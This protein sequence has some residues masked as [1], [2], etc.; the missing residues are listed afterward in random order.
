MKTP[1]NTPT[2]WLVRHGE[3]VDNVDPTWCKNAPRGA[4]DDPTLTNRGHQ[5]AIECGKRLQ[6]EPIDHIFCSPF[7]RCVQTAAGIVKQLKSP[8]TIKVEPGI[9]E[10]LYV[11]Q[12]PPG[13]LTTPELHQLYPDLIDLA[14]EPIIPKPG[15]EIRSEDGCIERMRTA[16]GGI[17]ARYPGNILLVSHGAPIAAA[18]AVLSG[19]WYY[20]GQCTVSK[21]VPAKTRANPYDAEF[22]AV[23]S[24]DS[25]HL[26]N[27]ANLRG[28]EDNPAMIKADADGTMRLKNHIKMKIARLDQFL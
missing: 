25:H 12:D 28:R 20:V 7:T 2:I 5:Q 14:Y 26:S 19:E 1:S 23:M 11:C 21:F 24:G 13:Y 17:R 4:W 8:L 3:R 10:T 27:R 18:H 15:P 9:C 22:I 16:I 6:N